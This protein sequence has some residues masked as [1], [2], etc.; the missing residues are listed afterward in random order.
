[1]P[2]LPEVHCH[3]SPNR[4]SHSRGSSSDA[5]PSGGA[6]TCTP[7]PREWRSPPRR[8]GGGGGDRRD[9]D[10]A[11]FGLGG[12]GSLEGF[13]LN[14][15]RV[16]ERSIGSALSTDGSMWRN[17][18]PWQKGGPAAAGPRSLEGTPGRCSS[19]DLI[20]TV[21]HED[22][23]AASFLRVSSSAWPSELWEKAASSQHLWAVAFAALALPLLV[24][25]LA[26]QVGVLGRGGNGEQGHLQCSDMVPC[27]P[28][29]LLPGSGGGYFC[30]EL[31][32]CRAGIDGPFK[33]CGGPTGQC[34]IGMTERPPPVLPESL[35]RAGT[36]D[37]RVTKGGQLLGCAS[38]ASKFK[39]QPKYGCTGEFATRKACDSA[40]H[41]VKDTKYV[42]AVHAGCQTARGHGTYA[43]G[44]DDGIG[45]KQCA[46]QTKYE[47]I[48]CPKG[49]ERTIDWQAEHDHHQDSVRRF[50][51]T[52]TCKETVWIR[53]AGAKGAVVESAGMVV[54]I[55]A[56]DHHSFAIPRTGLPATRFVPKVGCDA[57]GERCA[58]Q[59]SEP[60]P[61]GG[62]DEAVDTKFEA[63]WG[64]VFATGEQSNDGQRCAITEQG[65]PSTYQD[66]WDGSAVDG[67][68][69][70]FSVLV[71][72][73]NNS[74][75]PGT[76]GSPKVCAPVVCADLD[77]EKLC[78]RDE[79][80]TPEG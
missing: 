1:M 8:G 79:F 41:P 63:S 6:A 14:G 56:G 31:G 12:L 55:N 39:G 75:A 34:R 46:P 15:R 19:R 38:P 69:L 76:K 65:H 52:N 70:P 29:W 58:L 32:K 62:C 59:S 80:L 74:L 49:T 26:L 67:W 21:V 40:K 23:S 27:P 66:W 50:R 17:W 73:G 37:L 13:L 44:Y 60:C 16:A 24:C 22:E 48:L 45:L 4:S 42:S 28:D 7:S 68:T 57:Q 2:L 54:R 77:A 71:D 43:Y 5:S 33:D 53:Q 61:E 20:G 18:G 3:G 35:D 25:I 30:Q 36:F 78:P 9:S 10:R 72:D 64:C 11:D 51:V 47:W